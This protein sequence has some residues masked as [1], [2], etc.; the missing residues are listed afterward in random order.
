MC[1]VLLLHLWN[2]DK[3]K[4]KFEI[5]DYCIYLRMIS[6]MKLNINRL[7]L[8][9][10][11]SGKLVAVLLDVVVKRA[12]MAPYSLWDLTKSNRGKHFCCQ[13]QFQSHQVRQPACL[14]RVTQFR[15]DTSLRTI[16]RECSMDCRFLLQVNICQWKHLQAAH[17]RGWNAKHWRREVIRQNF[18][19]IIIKHL[20]YLL[21]LN[22]NRYKLNS[23]TA[24]KYCTVKEQTVSFSTS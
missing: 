17:L 15:S 21:Q 22:N 8:S 10:T 1:V 20:W 7:L 3:V 19:Y 13:N 16:F 18:N 24:L 14:H 12:A 2:T 9:L 5:F 11:C 6:R 4:V 23:C